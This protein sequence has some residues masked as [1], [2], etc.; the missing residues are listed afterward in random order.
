MHLLADVL[1][2]MLELGRPSRKAFAVEALLIGTL[3]LFGGA[4]IDRLGYGR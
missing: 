2:G 1:P 4:C 3:V